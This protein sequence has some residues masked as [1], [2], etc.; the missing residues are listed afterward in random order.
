MATFPRRMGSDWWLRRGAYTR[1]MVRELT[2]VFIAAYLVGFIV[3]LGRLGEGPEVYA[4]YVELLGSPG[5][6]LF[7]GV[8]FAASIVT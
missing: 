4:V 3:L 8:A 2:A 5:M 6:L 7:H 1:I